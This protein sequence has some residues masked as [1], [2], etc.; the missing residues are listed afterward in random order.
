MCVFL[1]NETRQRIRFS[2]ETIRF[3][4]VATVYLYRTRLKIKRGF[5]FQ[6]TWSKAWNS[7]PRQA[8]WK[9]D[10]RRE[11][12]SGGVGK[13]SNIY[14][15]IVFSKYVASAGI[16][17]VS[18]HS[19]RINTF[20]RRHGAR[21]CSPRFRGLMCSSGFRRDHIIIYAHGGRGPFDAIAGC[22]AGDA[23]GRAGESFERRTG[24]E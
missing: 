21:D 11:C 13:R 4:G 5:K 3:V 12:R 14:V 17:N 1:F 15:S 24:G 19:G 16:T 9:R 7:R 20:S 8:R 23:S 22:R 2:Y 10:G 18:L 6:S